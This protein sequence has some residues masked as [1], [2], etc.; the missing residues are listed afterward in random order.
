MQRFLE[1][2]VWSGVDRPEMTLCGW[3]DVEIQELRTKQLQTLSRVLLVI[4]WMAH[5]LPWTDRR[6][7]AL[8]KEA[9]S[10]LAKN[11]GECSTIDSLPAICFC[12]EV[13]ISSR[14]LLPHF[15]PGSVHSDTANWDECGRMFP[16][17]LRV[18]SFPDRFPRYA[19][20]EAVSPLKLRWVTS[21]CVFRCNLPPALLAEWSGSFA[22]HCGNKG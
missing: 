19:W 8:K 16:E 12:W 21:M 15:M 20:T 2:V 3:Q 22:C 4:R 18:S 7:L 1:S 10:S 5:N 6:L 9:F 17:K 14:T 11:F 13:E